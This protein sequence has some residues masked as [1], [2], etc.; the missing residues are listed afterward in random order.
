M[1][2]LLTRL[3]IR[4]S[5]DAVLISCS[6]EPVSLWLLQKKIGSELISAKALFCGSILDELDRYSVGPTRVDE[7]TGTGTARELLFAVRL[8]FSSNPHPER[9]EARSTTRLKQIPQLSLSFDT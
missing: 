1:A 2:F 3:S 7:T 4:T 8:S 6:F 9:M 5:S